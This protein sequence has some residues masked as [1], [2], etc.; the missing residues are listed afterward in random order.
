MLCTTELLT[1][2][3]SKHNWMQTNIKSKHKDVQWTRIS[4]FG[5]LHTRLM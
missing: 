5:C 2:D 4:C 1:L 3:S